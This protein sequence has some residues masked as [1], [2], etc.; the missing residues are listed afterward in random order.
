MSSI[1]RE[2]DTH[3]AGIHDA[4]PMRE[5]TDWLSKL[6]RPLP[7]SSLLLLTVSRSLR[8]PHARPSPATITTSSC[9]T[10]KELY[11]VTFPQVLIYALACP[12]RPDGPQ[13]NKFIAHGVVIA[14]SS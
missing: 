9:S 3:F 6:C 10:A 1:W 12:L 8:R 11:L 4:L 7:S 5:T 14:C 2:R 13:S